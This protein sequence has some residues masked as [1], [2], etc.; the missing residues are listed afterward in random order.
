MTLSNGFNVK[1]GL[2][3]VL[4]IETAVFTQMPVVAKLLT[5][6]NFRMSSQPINVGRFD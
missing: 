5:R 2:S 6:M 1:A 4:I 3:L